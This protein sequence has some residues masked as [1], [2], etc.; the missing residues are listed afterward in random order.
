MVAR[1]LLEIAVGERPMEGSDIAIAGEESAHGILLGMPVLG[2]LVAVF[3]AVTGHTITTWRKLSVTERVFSAVGVLAPLLLGA[4]VKGVPRAVV[5]T[6]RAVL[7]ALAARGVLGLFTKGQSRLFALRIVIGLRL[8]S[9]EDFREFLRIL[10]SSGSL[11]SAPHADVV[12]FT[13]CLTRCDYLARQAQWLAHAEAEGRTAG[14]GVLKGATPSGVEQ[15]IGDRLAKATGKPVTML[16]EILP[17]A[18]PNGKRVQGVTHPDALWGDDLCDF[19]EVR[20]GTAENAVKYTAAKARQANTVVVMLNPMSKITP[21]D[22]LAHLDNLWA[23]PTA[24]AIEQV[25]L[26]G[27]TEAQILERPGPYWVPLAR[28]VAR[29]TAPDLRRLVDTARKVAA[30][31][32]PGER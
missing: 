19:R 25:V 28:S 21:A 31:P 9:E 8:L 5:I 1:E 23:D 16:P 3:E 13:Y 10:R 30:E 7:T 24:L 27:D 17:E 11:K 2:E 22:Y 18:Y 32:E 14:Y 20:G 26:V 15:Q 29:A 12:H 4:A 6:R